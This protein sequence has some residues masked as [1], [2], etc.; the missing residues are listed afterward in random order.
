MAD[1]KQSPEN[2]SEL[3]QW[4]KR[5]VYA[6]IKKKSLEKIHTKARKQEIKQLAVF[7]YTAKVIAATATKCDSTRS[8]NLSAD[9]PHNKRKTHT[10]HRRPA[11]FWRG[12]KVQCG[13][14]VKTDDRKRVEQTS[15]S[16]TFFSY[17][18]SKAAWTY[19]KNW[20]VFPSGHLW[21]CRKN[22]PC[23]PKETSLFPPPMT[24][25]Q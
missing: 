24:A 7:W 16:C 4:K 17:D 15:R 19:Y 6:D 12:G 3:S 25:T 2:I 20:S 10:S 18:Q 9:S 21:Y 5:R 1:V 22:S 13:P 11:L 8:E 23:G 14:H